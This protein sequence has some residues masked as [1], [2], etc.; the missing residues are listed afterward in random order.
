MFFLTVACFVFVL[1]NRAEDVHAEVVHFYNS[2]SVFIALNMNNDCC[3]ESSHKMHLFLQPLL[4]ERVI[5]IANRCVDFNYD[6]HL[7]N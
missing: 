6:V 7:Y 2:M 4:L 1:E 5:F 3:A